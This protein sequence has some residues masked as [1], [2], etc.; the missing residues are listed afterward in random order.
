MDAPTDWHSPYTMEHT[1]HNRVVGGSNPPAATSLNLTFASA[2]FTSFHEHHSDDS[3]CS[4]VR[5][6]GADNARQVGG[7]M[8]S[9]NVIS[10]PLSTR[11]GGR[12]NDRS[13]RRMAKVATALRGTLQA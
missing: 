6:N 9:V 5:S 13:G 7:S 1:T 3:P 11:E 10:P 2:R 12:R 4:V 8:V